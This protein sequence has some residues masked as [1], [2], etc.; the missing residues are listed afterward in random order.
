MRSEVEA[1]L[2]A[3]AAH[4]V[5]IASH[6]IADLFDADPQRF[7]RF[8]IW[9]DDLLFDFSKHR[10]TPA[11]L[12][13]LVDLARTAGLEEARAALFGGEK[14]NHT[15]HRAALHMALRDLTGNPVLVDGR[16][17]SGDI[18]AERTKVASFASAVRDGRARGATG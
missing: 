15:E 4:R 6:R 1:A 2:A 5:E 11:T 3:L 8:S 13:H 17:V 16:D 7:S 14:I 10:I 9:L 18:A 12:D